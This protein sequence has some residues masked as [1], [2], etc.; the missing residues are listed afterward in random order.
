M[1]ALQNLVILEGMDVN[2]NAIQQGIAPPYPLSDS[3]RMLWCQWQTHNAAR[4]CPAWVVG[5]LDSKRSLVLPPC[6]PNCVRHLPA[7]S[8]QCT[9]AAPAM[10]QNRLS[11]ICCYDYAEKVQCQARILDFPTLILA[12]MRAVAEQGAWRCPQ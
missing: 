8:S 3:P 6:N 2:M 9:C 10:L 12:E 1:C 4:Q 7:A 11:C 5:G